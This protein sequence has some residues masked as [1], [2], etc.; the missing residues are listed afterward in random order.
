M[1]EHPIGRWRPWVLSGAAAVLV[2]AGCASN[3]VLY[4]N[5]HLKAVGE[6]QA[7]RDIE[8]CRQLAD[9]QVSSNRGKEVA[10]NTAIGAGVG[11]ASGTVGGAVA[12]NPG[13]GAAIGAASGAT[14]GFLRGLFYSSSKPSRAYRNYVDRCL[15][16]RGYEPMG[17]D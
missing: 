10:T 12:G 15:E 13:R 6:D 11:A 8:A 1:R 14:A 4:P 9:E 2:M 7:K 16:E 5:T 17:W 3:P